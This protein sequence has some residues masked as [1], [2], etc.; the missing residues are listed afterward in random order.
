MRLKPEQLGGALKKNLAP[1]YLLSGDEPQQMAELADQIRYAA[2][3]AGFESRE[4]FAAEANFNWQGLALSL[5]SYALFSDKKIVDLRLPTGAPGAEG[6]KVLQKYC[7]SPAEDILLLISAGKIASASLKSKWL[8]S[9]EHKGIFIQVWP[10]AVDQM[11]AWLERRLEMKGLSTDSEGLA[12]LTSRLEG[13]LMAA[14][15]EVE[16]LFVVYGPGRLNVQ[17]LAEAVSDSARYGVFALADSI[18][19][20]DAGRLIKMLTALQDEGVA[21]PVVLWAITRDIRLLIAVKKALAGGQALDT[22]FRDQKI[23]FNRK[24]LLG[25]ACKRLTLD[26]LNQSLLTCAAIDRRI[27]GRETGDAWELLLALCFDLVRDKAKAS[28]ALLTEVFTRP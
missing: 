6:A 8:Q 12:L 23:V 17:Q 28:P 21:A 5:N 14:A 13:N 18:W 16:K 19:S 24:T 9:I 15:Q 26:D 7:E 1:V 11:P 4:V 2:R 25:K 22:V 20:G 10:V 27:K 3:V